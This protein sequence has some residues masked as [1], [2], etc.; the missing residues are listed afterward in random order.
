MALSLPV[1]ATSPLRLRPAWQ[2]IKR[3][4]H[5]IAVRNTRFYCSERL[6][7]ATACAFRFLRQPSRPKPPRPVAND[8]LVIGVVVHT[9][10][11]IIR[12][13]ALARSPS[14]VL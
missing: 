2:L 10:G 5:L 11:Y 9:F 12:H 8:R 7:Q 4:R 1:T 14:T 3:L 6:A 13:A